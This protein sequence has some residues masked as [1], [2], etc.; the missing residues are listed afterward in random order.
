MYVSSSFHEN[1]YS[2]NLL[3]FRPVSYFSLRHLVVV[4]FYFLTSILKAFK[5]YFGQYIVIKYIDTIY[6]IKIKNILIPIT[7]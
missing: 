3:L 6:Y 5:K 7:Y 4:L 2:N 1:F